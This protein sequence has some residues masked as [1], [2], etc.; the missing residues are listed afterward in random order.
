MP[1]GLM[2]SV[3]AVLSPKLTGSLPR[4]VTKKA[5]RKMRHIELE[6]RQHDTDMGVFSISTKN[7]YYEMG[8]T[9]I[10]RILPQETQIL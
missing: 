7:I 3:S 2:I 10:I 5:C 1:F 6:P 9:R 4:N 8:T